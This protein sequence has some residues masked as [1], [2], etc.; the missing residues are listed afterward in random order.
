MDK[1]PTYNTQQKL[2]TKEYMLFDSF[3]RKFK[4]GQTNPCDRSQNNGYLGKMITEEEHGEAS[5]V[6]YLI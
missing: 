1:S 2:D 6:L 3:N 5:D 4:T